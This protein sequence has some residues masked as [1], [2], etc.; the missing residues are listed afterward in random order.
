MNEDYS[1]KVRWRMTCKSKSGSSVASDRWDHDWLRTKGAR[2]S[3]SNSGGPVEMPESQ[4]NYEVWQTEIFRTG[5]RSG[6]DDVLFRYRV[7]VK[8]SMFMPGAFEGFGTHPVSA[9]DV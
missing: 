2:G 1:G 5:P 7:L 3:G 9:D 6:P 8:F 4:K